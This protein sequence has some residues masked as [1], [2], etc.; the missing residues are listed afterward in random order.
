MS[1]SHQKIEYI[2]DFIAILIVLEWFLKFVHLS[3]ISYEK[4]QAF[5]FLFILVLA[6][7]LVFRYQQSVNKKEFINEHW[8][9][10]ISLIPM[11]P[12]L[13]LFRIMRIIRKSRLKNL[14]HLIRDLLKANSLIY[15]ILIVILLTIFG[16]GLL[17]RV[18]GRSDIPT[19]F[20]G[21]WF[22]FVTMTTVGYGDYTPI[23]YTGRLIAMVLMITG[24]G[25]LG[26]LTGSIASFFTTRNKQRNI[27]T[28]QTVTLDTHG[29]NV[30]E[31]HDVQNY[32]NYLKS[33]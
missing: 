16:G 13:R 17:F 7:D 10:F 31:L 33:K 2:I 20:D 1:K 22:A 3:S 27:T 28:K 18:E 12:V 9:E 19:V 23:T 15:V 24:M 30:D 4:S 25:F 6:I 29:L 11:I 8:I 21:I 26:V 5:D 14:F 32:I